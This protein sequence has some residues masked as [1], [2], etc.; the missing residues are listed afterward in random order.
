[1]PFF[2]HEGDTPVKGAPANDET[3]PNGQFHPGQVVEADVNPDPSV[4][5]EVFPIDEV[6]EEKKAKSTEHASTDGHAVK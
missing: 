1:V 6:P 3:F 4:F 5:R 2:V